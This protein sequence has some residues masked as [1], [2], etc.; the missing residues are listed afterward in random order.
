MALTKQTVDGVTGFTT[1]GDGVFVV[2]PGEDPIDVVNAHAIQLH[3][4]RNLFGITT[5]GTEDLTQAIADIAANV[6]AIALNTTHRSSD[7]SDHSFLDQDVTNGSTPTF[8]G[9]NFTNIP[10]TGLSSIVS[11]PFSWAF[12][13]DTAKA[14]PGSGTFRMN[15]AAPASVAELYVD[16]INADGL[17][18]STIIGALRAM[19]HVMIVEKGAAGTKSH[20][21]KISGTPVDET[22]YF[23]IPVTAVT[24]QSIP[25][26]G[27]VCELSFIGSPDI[28]RNTNQSVAQVA[29]TTINSNL[30]HKATMTTNQSGVLALH[31]NAVAGDEYRLRVSNT[32]GHT[33][34]MTAFKWAGGVAGSLS[35]GSGD[36]DLIVFEVISSTEIWATIA[37]DGG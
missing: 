33:L 29:T 34:D 22:G 10:P 32:G 25:T 27:A 28:L 5:D 4:N 35:T 11:Q 23:T 20:L 26:N 2:D 12:D 1:D 14:D 36:L 7:G 21:F 6:A 8:D 24:T 37:N 17:D 31:S 15:N 30:G 16:D 9:A 19:Q 18:I 3:T 13:S